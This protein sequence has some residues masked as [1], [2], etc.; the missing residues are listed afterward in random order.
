MEEDN[1]IITT[2]LKQ[3]PSCITAADIDQL[4]QDIPAQYHAA[5]WSAHAL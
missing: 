2:L 1:Q 3:V 4:I 5:G